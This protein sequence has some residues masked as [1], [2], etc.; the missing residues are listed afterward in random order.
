MAYDGMVT[1]AIAKELNERTSRGKVEK[2]YQ[3]EREE[4]VL[5]IRTREGRYKLYLSCAG[6]HCGAYLSEEEYTNPPSPSAFCMLLRK[7]LQGGVV[8]SVEQKDCERILE[9]SVEAFD[10]LGVKS[11]RRLIVEIMGRHSNILLVGGDGRIL[12]AVKRVSIDVN[13]DRQILPGFAYEYPPDGGKI[14]F[15]KVT[16][17]DILEMPLLSE[18]DPADVLLAH[19]QGLSPLTARELTASYDLPAI[20][21]NEEEQRQA[22]GTIADHLRQMTAALSC[23]GV[24]PCV[25]IKKDG[26]PADF[27]VLPVMQY[28]EVYEKR[29]FSAASEAVAWYYAHRDASKRIRQRAAD[30]TKSVNAA[31]KKARLK[32][33]R[34]LEDLEE[35]RNGEQ[36]RLYGELLTANLHAFRTGDPAVT[37]TNYYN[38]EPVTIPLDIRYA[39]AKNAQ[40]YFKKYS[41][42]KNALR[43]KQIRLEETDK[44]IA[45]LESVLDLAERAADVTELTALKEELI[46]TGFVRRR[47]QSRS[48]GKKDKPQP[49]VYKSTSG[50]DILAGRNNKENDYLTF[51]V[52][53]RNDL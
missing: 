8:L 40:L 9:I 4:I 29:P 35:A 19:I 37:V 32:K 53:G 23:G 21:E 18:R 13:K 12:D 41:K 26:T 47:K 33:Q 17:Q 48:P 30:V 5:L 46:E 36:Y 16:A 31:L 42:S 52:A 27:H 7:H 15:D 49:Y 43:E 34:I 45:Y 6:S 44:D 24:R 2:I 11:T 51:R 25:Y 50:L 3:P 38:N 28:E 14:P 10:E 1:R 39:P 22:A 20:W